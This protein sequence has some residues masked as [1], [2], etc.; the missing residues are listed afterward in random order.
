[1]KNNPAFKYLWRV[2]TTGFKR[3]VA[4]IVHLFLR[5]VVALITCSVLNNIFA[6]VSGN[7]LICVRVMQH[8]EYFIGVGCAVRSYGCPS[9]VSFE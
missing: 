6:L 3:E 8:F 4:D 7:F 2:E 5:K 1:M 9:F